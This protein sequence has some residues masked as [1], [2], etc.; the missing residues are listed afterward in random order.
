MT[1]I[2]FPSKTINRKTPARPRDEGIQM[3][4]TSERKAFKRCQA[5]WWWQYREGLVPVFE[6]PGALWF[7]TGLHAV[8]EHWYGPGGYRRGKNPLGVWRDYVGDTMA[9]VYEEGG[10]DEDELKV[11]DARELGEAMIGA[12][13]DKYGKDSNW[14]VEAVEAPFEIDLQ[15]PRGQTVRY[16]GKVDLVA[17]NEDDGRRYIWDHKHV[18]SIQT[19]YLALDDQAGA[20]WA[21]APSALYQQG[22]LKTA[23]PLAGIMFNFLR[24]AKPDDR[25]VNADGKATNKPLKLH[26]ED[27]LQQAGLNPIGTVATLKERAEAA[28][29]VVLGDVS[30]TQPKPAFAREFVWRTPQEQRTQIA[31]IMNEARHMDAIRRR[32]L[33]IIKNPTGDCSW[34]CP[35]VPMCELQEQRAD[36][37]DFRSLAYKTRDLYDEHI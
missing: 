8:W 7:G 5:K 10:A 21:L 14:Y 34:D 20:Y 37:K 27:A 36:W 16:V 11:V 25:P 4:R 29:L 32:E 28:G 1:V 6:K 18:K 23:E 17:R 33:P 9:V 2:P 3:L 22:I 26:Y 19:Q 35:F 30:K 15:G 12:Y 24:K 13:L 31:K